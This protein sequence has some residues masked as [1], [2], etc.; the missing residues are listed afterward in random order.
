M[1]HVNRA[2]SPK[3]IE[4]LALDF[5]PEIVQA[6]CI[7]PTEPETPIVIAVAIA[8]PD[9]MPQPSV[10]MRD[11][12]A[13]FLSER[14]ASSWTSADF[15][16]VGP[17]FVRVRLTVELTLAASSSAAL[18]SLV[19]D[20]LLRF[21]HPTTGGLDGKGWPFGRGL[22][23]SDVHRALAGTLGEADVFRLEVTRADGGG[24]PAPIGAI[25][26]ITTLADQDDVTAILS[27]AVQ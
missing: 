9:P 22:W 13:R 11:G 24:D 2:I 12:L 17:E 20:R 4:A 21:L 7:R 6:R 26:I 3:D 8:S 15:R 23:A 25:S 18:P 27:E 1:R 10:A 19:R 14:A 16:V 5:A